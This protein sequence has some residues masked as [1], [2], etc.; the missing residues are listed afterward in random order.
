MTQPNP[1][2]AAG[3]T[4]PAT[5]QN[6]SRCRWIRT[7]AAFQNAQPLERPCIACQRVLSAGAGATSV[8]KSTR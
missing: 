7:C 1:R 2:A 4:L 3:A 5:A 8:N 6:R